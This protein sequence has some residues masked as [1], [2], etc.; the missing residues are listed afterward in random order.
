MVLIDEKTTVRITDSLFYWNKATGL[1][2]EIVGET[3]DELS[4]SKEEY[5]K[6]DENTFLIDGRMRIDE[7][8]RKLGLELPENADYETIAGFVLSI[9]GHIPK[10]KEQA[11]H[12]NLLLTITSMRGFRVKEVRVTK[13]VNIPSKE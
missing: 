11:E 8:N 3:G 5:Q 2:E 9:L 4:P 13:K 6:I 7:T 1:A 12:E 10:V